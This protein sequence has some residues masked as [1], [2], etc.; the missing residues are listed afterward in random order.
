V[1]PVSA[2]RAEANLARKVI[3]LERLYRGL[4]PEIKYADIA[5]T[6]VN[7]SSANG[8]VVPMTAIAQGAGVNQRISENIL[9]KH[10]EFHMEVFY[11]NS[12]STSL[13]DNGT[14][15]VYV[16]QDKQQIA[17][18]APACVDLVDQPSLPS[19]QLLQVTEQKR[20]RILYD[21]GPQMLYI[22][23]GGV[24]LSSSAQQS[25]KWQLHFKR[26]KYNIPVEYNGVNNTDIQKNGIYFCIMT[27]VVGAAGANTLD[28]QGTSRVGYTDV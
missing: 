28:F 18:T 10:V 25:T 11:L 9:V 2:A 15:R 20:F 22:G 21:S 26:T 14:Y 3:R 8:L 19:I 5:L 23:Q 24:Y 13:T 7:V 6:S 17:D 1:V 16:I 12:I 27:D 4:Q